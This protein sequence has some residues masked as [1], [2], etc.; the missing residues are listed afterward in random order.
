MKLT[1]K[2]PASS[3]ANGIVGIQ[4]KYGGANK[5]TRAQKHKV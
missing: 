4:V 1:P 5:K 2:A 3:I